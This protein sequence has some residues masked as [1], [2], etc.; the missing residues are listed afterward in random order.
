M[1]L[2]MELEDEMIR[3]YPLDA[4]NAHQARIANLQAE[5]T[6]L[7]IA[8]DLGPRD[9]RRRCVGVGNDDSYFGY[10]EEAA[11]PSPDPDAGCIIHHGT[12]MEQACSI[13]STETH[14]DCHLG[15]LVNC[16]PYDIVIVLDDG[17]HDVIPPSGIVARVASTQADYG[18]IGGRIPVATRPA[19]GAVE[20]LETLD[21]MTPVIVSIVAAPLVAATGRPTFTPD[22]GPDSV[23]QNPNEAIINVRRL[24]RWEGV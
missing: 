2:G 4:P 8:S 19:Y 17:E 1:L 21:P 22:T 10:A 23:V 14:D 5:L 20:G 15:S 7:G 9:V 18:T 13:A 6:V 24:V 3:L 11:V 12:A 16:T